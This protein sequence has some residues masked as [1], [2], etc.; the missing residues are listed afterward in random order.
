MKIFLLLEKKIWDLKKW[1]E[2]TYK[3][4]DKIHS[5][6]IDNPLQAAVEH[7]PETSPPVLGYLWFAFQADCRNR[8]PA[9]KQHQKKIGSRRD[10]PTFRHPFRSHHQQAR[11]E[12][13]PAVVLPTAAGHS[14]PGPEGGSSSRGGLVRAAL[15]TCSAL[16][17][18]AS[19]SW[20]R[21]VLSCPITSSQWLGEQAVGG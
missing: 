8:H 19:L 18:W 2:T 5:V 9:Q 16:S 15:E 1:C 20:V 3:I 12:P 7:F 10:S 13:R 14:G 17:P 4:E 6:G 21:A 11:Q